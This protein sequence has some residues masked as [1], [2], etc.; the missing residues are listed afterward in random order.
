M[1]L[2]SRPRRLRRLSGLRRMSR[3]TRLSAANLVAPFFVTHGRGIRRP[4]AS[5]PG[6]DQI[7]V[8]ELV[9]DATIAFELGIPAVLLFGIPARKDATGSEAWA[10][11]G[12]IQ[13]AVR[14]LKA[15]L[16]ELVV[17]TDLC[18]CEYTSHGHCGVLTKGRVDND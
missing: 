15:R 10:A 5:M 18:F 8:D 9:H 13:K 3:E 4:I 1:S 17:I 7:S 2:K 14:A 16:P 11:G 12:I 6:Q